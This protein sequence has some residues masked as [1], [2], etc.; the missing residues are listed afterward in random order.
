MPR[1]QTWKKIGSTVDSLGNSMKSLGSVLDGSP[2]N[3]KQKST[4]AKPV[5]KRLGKDPDPAGGVFWTLLGRQWLKRIQPLYAARANA[6]RS[7]GSLYAF[8]GAQLLPE[9]RRS[10]EAPLRE[11]TWHD[12]LGVAGRTGA[13]LRE[14][15]KQYKHV[16]GKALKKLCHRNEIKCKKRA[17]RMGK[18]TEG[19]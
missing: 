5:A 1:P 6:Y 2:E 7:V 8:W 13:E 11:S 19:A 4:A 15:Q 12:K 3:V 10:M 16:M 17:T 14:L 9:V 18:L